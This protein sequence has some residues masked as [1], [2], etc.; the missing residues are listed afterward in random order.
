V[1][2]GQRV[3]VN[4]IINNIYN[5]PGV[6]VELRSEATLIDPPLWGVTINGLMYSLWEDE[7]T[8]N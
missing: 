4:S 1:T 3:I 6:I 2:I 5:R 8:T 7:L